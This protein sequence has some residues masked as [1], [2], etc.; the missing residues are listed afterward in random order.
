VRQDNGYQEQ[1][2]LLCNGERGE[3][4]QDGSPGGASG[5]PPNVTIS[6]TPGCLEI[7][8][9]GSET[10]CNGTKGDKGDKGDTGDSGALVADTV[11]TLE[12]LGINTAQP[13]ALTYFNSSRWLASLALGDGQLAIGATGGPP[14]A[15]SLTGTTNQIAVTPGAGTITLSTPQSIHT[16]ASPTFAGMTVSGLTNNALV[17]GSTL[18]SLALTNGQLPI[19]STGAAPVAAS[20]TGTANQ[21]TVTPGAGSI[22]LSTPQNI[23]TG[24]SPT[25]TGL[26]VSGLTANSLVLGSTLSSLTLTN[27]QIPIGNTGNAPS[28]ATITG[29]T[30]RITV[31]PGAGTITLTTPQDTH[32]AATPTF[33]SQTLTATSNQLVLGTTRTATLTAPTPATASR[34]YTFPDQGGDY[35]VVATLGAQTINGV[36]TFANGVASQSRIDISCSGC[37]QIFMKRAANSFGYYFDGSTSGGAGPAADRVLNFVDPG[38]NANVVLSEGAATINGAKTLTSALTITPTSNQIVLGTTNT[39]TLS[40]NA[41]SAPRTYAFADPG[42]SAFVVMTEGGITINGAKTFTRTVAS[43]GN[44]EAQ[45]FCRRQSQTNGWF[46]DCADLGG[47]G[48]SG[49]RGANFY[50]PGVTSS[51]FVLS[52]GAVT[53]NGHKTF[54]MATVTPPNTGAGT[55]STAMTFNARNASSINVG[56]AIGNTP[57]NF[58]FSRDP[59]GGVNIRF[60]TCTLQTTTST[61]TIVTRGTIPSWACPTTEDHFQKVVVYIN[62]AATEGLVRVSTT[63]II[64]W[65]ASISEANF[66]TATANTGWKAQSI[67]Y[68]V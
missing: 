38:T 32:T 67:S 19:G 29:T 17:Y 27:G 51:Y 24:S 47:N 58:I 35:S 62:N 45:F 60:G 28:A 66:N 4:G 5:P 33:A 68:A 39:V 10:L 23:G 40:G 2:E 56:G 64:T 34:T 1:G 15:A 59:S 26:T 55:D 37:A 43:I 13:N 54:T 18:T 48:P 21:I 22:T 20:L 6:S 14:V 49:V 42:A 11:L 9:V 65:Y 7:S 3:R 12:R 30:N 16:G 63:C 25:F 31:T 8:G 36:K 41:P 52:E 46:I 50:D 57:V 61:A 44:G 53:I